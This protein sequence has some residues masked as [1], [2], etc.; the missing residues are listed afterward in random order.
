MTKTIQSPVW[1]RI[2]DPPCPIGALLGDP[3]ELL[4][5]EI[6][7]RIP[8]GDT[9]EDVIRRCYNQLTLVPRQRQIIPSDI[10]YLYLAL[11]TRIRGQY[12]G[13]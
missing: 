10:I 12:Y 9:W 3:V 11:Y 2:K 6:Q 7:Q 13:N 1:L 5:Q 4:K 8:F